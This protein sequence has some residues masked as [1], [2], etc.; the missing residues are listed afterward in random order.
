MITCKRVA[1]ESVAWSI[2]RA[3]IEMY[4]LFKIEV[5]QFNAPLHGQYLFPR[6]IV[7]NTGLTTL[8]V[9]LFVPLAGLGVKTM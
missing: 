7:D 6:Y 2:I 8:P 1:L 3:D 4:G 9:S 5:F